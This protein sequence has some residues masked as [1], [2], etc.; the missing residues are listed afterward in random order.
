MVSRLGV[1]LVAGLCT[2]SVA[3]AAPPQ[4]EFPAALFP[5][6]GTNAPGNLRAF[7]FGQNAP[8][9]DD[10]GLVLR[11]GT[12][13]I[14]ADAQRI[15]CC[16]IV[17]R[18]AA[19][20]PQGQATLLLSYQGVD[21][22]SDFNVEAG[23]DEEPPTVD[24]VTIL[25]DGPGQLVAAF[26]ASDNAQVVG[27]VA[28]RNG[29][30]VHAAPV[31]TLLEMRGAEA[32][33]CFYV[34]ALDIAGNESEEVRVCDR[35]ATSD[36]GSEADAGTGAEP[37]LDPVGCAAVGVANDAKAPLFAL[38]A[39]GL[40]GAAWSRRRRALALV[41][42][43]CAVV[44]TAAC[45]AGTEPDAGGQDGGA[46]DAGEVP[47][48][49]GELPRDGGAPADAG[50]EEVAARRTLTT[51]DAYAELE[52]D[53]GRV[54]Y[55][56]SVEGREDAPPVDDGC[57]FQNHSVYAYHLEYLRAELGDDFTLDDYTA[58]TLDRSTRVWWGGELWWRP[59]MLH[60]VSGDQGVL[61]YLVYATEDAQSALT[62]ADV[63]AAHFALSE[64]APAFD[65]SLAFTPGSLRQRQMAEAERASLQGD[66]IGV[67]LDPT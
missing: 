38:A 1:A 31:G 42:I 65:A 14:E 33:S 9:P 4:G 3:F 21:L 27:A 18:P 47:P 7:A 37:E 56:A 13:P 54:R 60:P 46:R 11:F 44:G 41:V 49:A 19:L 32:G 57:R 48:D 62:A 59:Q 55:L 17:L 8:S 64:C 67:V 20:L 16:L 40:L 23:A 63:R 53:E 34:S 50:Q 5:E 66:G 28:R 45:P 15:G 10:V 6:A 22:E 52:S 2:T 39:L 36:G 29:V 24:D 30:V 12:G 26:E 58:M 35:G 61:L 25:D 43:A 51:L